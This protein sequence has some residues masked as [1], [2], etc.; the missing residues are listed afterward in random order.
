MINVEIKGFK[1][2]QARIDGLKPELEK[3]VNG[4]LQRGAALMVRNAQRD[5]PVNQ[6]E[7]GGNLKQG[8]SF[9]PNPVKGLSVEVVSNAKYSPYVEWGTIKYVFYG[10]PGITPEIES[11]ALQFKGKGIRKN[12]GLYPQPFFFKQVPLAK[13]SIERDIENIIKSLK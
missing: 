11:Y 1:E 3:E 2:L 9:F 7:G 6:E 4:V 13:A 8:I 12:G 10:Q 5:A